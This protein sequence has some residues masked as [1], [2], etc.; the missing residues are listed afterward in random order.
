MLKY[1]T[2]KR[3]KAAYEFLEFKPEIKKIENDEVSIV[4][5]INDESQTVYGE[6]TNDNNKAKV[7][8]VSAM[9]LDNYKKIIQD[10]GNPAEIVIATIGYGAVIDHTYFKDRISSDYY[11]FIENTKE[12]HETIPQG[13]RT[14]EVIRECTTDNIKILPLVVINDQN[15][16]TTSSILQAIV[17]AIQKSDVICYEFVH[18]E[19]YMISLALENAFKENKPIC[20]ITK[21]AVDDEDIFP[22]NNP[23]TIAI[24]SVDKS[25]KTTSYSGSGDYIDF[26][27][28]STD[29]EEIFNSSSSVSKWSGAGYSNAQIASI[30][31]LIKTYNKDFTILEVY[32]VIRN[33]CQDLGDKGKDINYGYG[34]PN[35]SNIKI[36]DID[37]TSPELKQEDIKFSDEQWEKVK[38]VQIKA[39]DNIKIYGWN[40]TNSKDAP[41][42]WNKLDKNLNTLDVTSEIKENGSYYA[43]VTDSAGNAVYVG[44]DVTKVDN[45]SPKITYTIDDS[46]KDTEKYIT[47]NVTATDEESGLHDMPYSW[48][49]Q[50]WGTDSNI[51]KVTKNGTYKIYVRDKLENISE[52]EIRINSFPIEGTADIDYGNLIKEI[53]VSSNWSG[54]T[55]NEVV[56]TFNDNL[57]IS[58]WE[59][60]EVDEIPERFRP[61]QSDENG[62]T[63]NNTT[64]ENTTSSAVITSSSNSQGRTNF[65]ITAALRINIQYYLWVKDSSGN[66]TSQGFTIRK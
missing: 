11:N 48:D 62:N 63:T 39:K 1:D 31:A 15:Y 45:I 29:V 4:K 43:W 55:N 54:S 44:F 10:N 17:Y 50:S 21:M 30:I 19:N 22:A 23:T 28:S 66:I 53:K 61:T 51:L 9:G 16:T 8:G 58:D 65:T 47:I 34:F 32:N 7:Y 52:K 36:A 59:I 37:K 49:K 25:L 24:S 35:F 14:L 57:N 56:I 64:I 20:C 2:Q 3:A 42:E 40:V 60:T 46:K 38:N 5:P 41:K 12:I 33:Y 13:S 6:N 18:K 26:V 27:A